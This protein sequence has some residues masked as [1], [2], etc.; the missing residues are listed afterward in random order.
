MPA[1]PVRKP[2]VAGKFYAGSL[3]ELT[4]QIEECFL[5]P[6]GPGTLPEC[7][8]RG[9]R[10]IAGLVCP[11]AG[12][13]FSGPTA[14]HAYLALADDGCPEVLVVIG[15]NHGRGGFVSAV[16]T[17]GAWQTPLGQ[18]PIE[19]AIAAAIA[20]ALP[21]F[22]TDPRALTGEH[23]LEVQ[24]PFLQYIYEEALMFVPVM[25]AA[26]DF[27]AARTVGQAVAA[28]LE[29]R[30][31]VVI[32]STDMTHYQSPATARQQDALLIRR[33]EALDPEGL[34][35]ERD[36]RRISM[37]GAGPVAATLVAAEAL[38]A[39]NVES[40]SYSTSGDVMPSDQVV[41]YYAAAIRR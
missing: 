40:L 13:V 32:A 33:I 34:I 16:Q 18:V 24:L 29:G 12:Y 30:D 23:S 36:A 10:E 7:D 35:A 8:S 2:A 6:L 28:A 31:A 26:Q 9:P 3:S 14:A 17:E 41:G 15:L 11:H 38:G 1:G 22:E 27:G 39:T 37:C 20:S 21:D 5:G 4:A 25:M 19:G